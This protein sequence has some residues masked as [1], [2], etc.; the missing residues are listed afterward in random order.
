MGTSPKAKSLFFASGVIL[1]WCYLSIDRS[2]ESEKEI[3]RKKKK[4]VYKKV[5]KG[6]KRG[7]LHFCGSPGSSPV[8]VRS[9]LYYG[10][11]VKFKWIFKF[12]FIVE[13]NTILH[14]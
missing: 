14:R 1:S 12:K 11:K 5:L 10:N 6:R 3:C 4:L 9:K 8:C 13:I 2:R 7:E